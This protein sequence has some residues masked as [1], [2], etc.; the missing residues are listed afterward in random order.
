VIVPTRGRPE[1]LAECLTALGELDYPGDQ[2]EVVVVDDDGGGLQRERL[3]RC[4]GGRVKLRIAEQR[5]AG[6]GAARNAGAELALGDVLAFTDDDCCPHP[7]W[8]RRLVNELAADPEAAAGGH[9]V[10]ALRANPFSIAS[11]LIIDAGYAHHNSDGG[12]ARFLTTNNLVVGAIGFHEVG[13]FDPSFTT[14]EDRDFCDRW[15]SS[16][17]RMTYVPNAIVRHAHDLSLAAFVRQHFAY[18]RGAFRFHRAHARRSGGRVE[19]DI[20]YYAGLPSLAF[21]RQRPAM[22][23]AVSLLLLVWQVA[24]TA[25]FCWEWLAS[26][27]RR[28]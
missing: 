11:Q 9:T 12:R 16:G 19:P 10:N 14:S 4:L 21:R 8:L 2:L 13:G 5:R 3:R 28:P 24:N 7:L 18:G 6:P 17:R 25:G 15:V 20:S 26:N 23:L 1:Q 27:A 22:A